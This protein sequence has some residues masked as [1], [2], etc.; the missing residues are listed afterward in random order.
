MELAF[1]FL[2]EAL[3]TISVLVLIG[4]GLSIIFGMMQVINLAH[5]EF[6]VLGGYIAITAHEL[7]C[8]IFVAIL[9][10][11]PSIVCIYGII[12]ERLIVRRFYNRIINTMLASWGLSLAMIGFF[13][14]VFG[15]TTTGISSPIGSYAIGKYQLSGYNLFVIFVAIG[16]L[17]GLWFL[18]KH[19]R[20]GLIA[21]ATMKN[22][23]MASAFGYN[24]SKVYMLT[25]AGGAF[26]AG[27]A[28]AV[29]S[30]LVGLGPATGGDFIAKAFITVI[31]GGAS[32]VSG[33][34]SS[35]SSL[36]LVTQGLS[37]IFIQSV[38]EISL[39]ILAIILL[40]LLPKGIS[41]KF[42]KNRI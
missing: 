8:N 15:N 36:G 4:S 41:G 17:A 23:E 27:L 30:P 19:T 22:P 25:F 24:P 6:L 33:L 40:V 11:A 9:I 1:I 42:F 32:V 18:L 5:G 37:F 28:G 31:V 10:I 34:I 12:I 35:A 13:T 2:L 29:I 20:M 39:L 26:L 7:G 38:G 3:Y 16:V 21:Q 14:M